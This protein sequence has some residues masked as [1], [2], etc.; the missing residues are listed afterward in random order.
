MPDGKKLIIT[1]EIR[2]H[3]VFFLVDV[4]SVNGGVLVGGAVRDYIIR[5]D[6]FKDLDFRF[7]SKTQRNKFF[8]DLIEK[9]NVD[10][11]FRKQPSSINKKTFRCT[12][13]FNGYHINVDLCAKRRLC[14]HDYDFVA[15]GVTYDGKSL[16]HISGDKDVLRYAIQHISRG[17]LI[18]GPE[19][20]DRITKRK[21][22]YIARIKKYISRGWVIIDEENILKALQS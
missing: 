6:R 14:V 16:G 7:F 22:Y 12:V 1:D 13:T 2:R 21:S 11:K 10:I 8:S 9:Y 4:A 18:P 15:N 17:V 20:Y 19:L 5:G 3:C